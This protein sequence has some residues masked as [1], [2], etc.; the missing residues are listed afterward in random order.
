[1]TMNKLRLF[2]LALGVSALGCS[3]EKNAVQDITGPLAE[4]RIKFFHFGLNAPGVYF[5]A[6]DVKMAALSGSGATVNTATGV[7]SGGTESSTGTVYGGV[8]AG[9]FYSAIAPGTY[10]FA[11]KIAAATDNGLAISTVSSA[12][13][14]NT[15]YSMYISGVYDATAK[16]AEAF[17]VQ[18]S[19]PAD[20]D[21]TLAYVRFVNAGPTSNPLQLYG[22]NTTVGTPE[23]AIGAITAYKAGSAFVAVPIG[24]YN[25][26]AREAGSSTAKITRTAVSFAA[27]RVYTIALRGTTT[28]F[29]DNTTNR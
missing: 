21:W 17:V 10:T 23:A 11:A 19:Y 18:D 29:L 3:F 8:T 1:M 5:Y 22:T 4:S 6:N 12:L 27:G 14:A 2:A 9:G 24:V 13:A 7:S 15:S 16:K 20:F 26:S 25:L 28:L